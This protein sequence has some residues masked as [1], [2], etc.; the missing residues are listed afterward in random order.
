MSW[1]AGKP[2]SSTTCAII[3][4]GVQIALEP[5]PIASRSTLLLSVPDSAP[6]RARVTDVVRTGD[7]SE[8]RSVDSL[9]AL[10]YDELKAMAHRQLT[11]EQAGHSLQTTALVH[12]AYLKL[13]DST[14]V[15]RNGRGYFFAAASRAM[16]Q[17]L[18]E[19]AR[20][21][22]ALKRGAGGD[23]VSLD[24]AHLAVDA[25]AIE[26]LDLDTALER[27]AELNPR[28]A[29]VVE[30]VYFGGLGLDE[31]AEVLGVS[32]RTV[33]YDWALARAWLYDCLKLRSDPRPAPP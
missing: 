7:P 2:V 5:L 4:A 11:R 20:Q 33:K 16:R 13:V 25:F 8:D 6:L 29:R 30:C 19:H 10:V 28:Q 24:D 15:G 26:L 31:T 22:N 9:V 3:A 21:R 17:V 14:N 32:P 23:P 12:E 1:R 27:L 18:V